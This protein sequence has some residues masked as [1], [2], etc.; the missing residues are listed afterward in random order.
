MRCTA[1]DEATAVDV[2][3]YAARPSARHHVKGQA[4]A[5]WTSNARGEGGGSG[6]RPPLRAWSMPTSQMSGS[7]PSVL[8]HRR[9]EDR[10]VLG[11]GARAEH[12][13]W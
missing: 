11:Y 8:S 10:H 9:V 1:E 7:S 4:V 6:M 5:I 12:G 2:Q 3:E 13:S